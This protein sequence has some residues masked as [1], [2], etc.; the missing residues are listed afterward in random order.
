[1]TCIGG[2]FSE[3]VP[4]A[5]TNPNEAVEIESRQADLNSARVVKTGVGCEIRM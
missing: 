3:Q 5:S 1:V 4:H 2:R